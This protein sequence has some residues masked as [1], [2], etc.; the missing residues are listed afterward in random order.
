MSVSVMKLS[1]NNCGIMADFS[2]IEV[3]L[4]YINKG[5]KQRLV[6]IPIPLREIASW[7]HFLQNVLVL[8]VWK[9]VNVLDYRCYLGLRKS[10]EMHHC[11]FQRNCCLNLNW[12]IKSKKIV[13]LILLKLGTRHLTRETGLTFTNHLDL[14]CFSFTHISPASVPDRKQLIQRQ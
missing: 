11:Y 6:N 7:K 13:E 1:L 14:S 2:R 10:K 9:S 12:L 5:A 8:S 3:T 4:N